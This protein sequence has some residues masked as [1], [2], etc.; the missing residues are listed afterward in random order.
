MQRCTIFFIVVGA[1]HV[2]SGKTAQNMQSTDD[3]KEYCIA[4]H[5]VGCALEYI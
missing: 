2:S 4:L 3:S 5:L 1:L